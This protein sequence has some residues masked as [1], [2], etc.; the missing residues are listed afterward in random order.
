MI[1]RWNGVRLT[2]D[3]G[4][5]SAPLYVGAPEIITTPLDANV[6][7]GRVRAQIALKRAQS[8]TPSAKPEPA[9]EPTLTQLRFTQ[10]MQEK[11]T[12]VVS[13]DLKGPLT[14]IRMAQFMLRD[15]LRDNHEARP[16]LEVRGVGR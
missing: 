9:P 15:I 10:D 12:R 13:H 6:V 16:I 11:F 5:D 2:G 7:R 14:N 4:S 3:L 8:Q 1:R